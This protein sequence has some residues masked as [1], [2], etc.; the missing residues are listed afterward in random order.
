MAEKKAWEIQSQNQNKIEVC[1]I[2]P[3]FVLGPTYKTDGFSSGDIMKSLVTGKIPLLPKICLPLIDVRNVAFAHL[4]AI[5]VPEAANQRFL[6]VRRE[7]VLFRKLTDSLNEQGWKKHFPKIPTKNLGKWVM[8]VAGIF[9]KNAKKGKKLW[10]VTP[11]FDTS[12]TENVL[13]VKFIDIKDTVNDMVLSMAQG[14]YIKPKKIEK[15]VGKDSKQF[16][17]EIIYQ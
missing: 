5:L 16:L 13:G 12:N 3:A 11:T 14:L 10:G 7:G 15:Y 8:S 1:T 17:K 4:Q 2:C 6:L 9:S